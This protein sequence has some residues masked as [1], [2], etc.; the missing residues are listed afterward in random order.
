MRVLGPHCLGLINTDPAVRM[1]ATLAPRVPGPGRLGFFCQSGALGIAVLAEAADRAVGLSSFASAGEQGGVSGNDLMQFWY[2]DPRTE[3]VLLWLESFG[4]PRKFARLAR[5][6][7]RRK[8]VVA[9]KSGRHAL[10]S[11]GLAASSA[12]V[13]AQ[14]GRDPVRPVGGAARRH[15]D[16]GVRSHDAAREPAVAGR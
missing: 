1:N 13:S 15:P 14:R 6:L 10:V 2:D 11:P 16:P 7:A 9:L 3:V 4:N 5:A 12:E 8:P